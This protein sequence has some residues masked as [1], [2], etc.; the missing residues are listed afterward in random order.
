MEV[1]GGK[2][3]TGKKEG[4]SVPTS[5]EST[6]GAPMPQTGSSLAGASSWAAGRA[7]LWGRQATLA[8]LPGIIP[9][10]R[11]DPVSL[12]SRSLTQH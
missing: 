8:A 12:V 10:R 11:N 6:L 9:C 1:R 7:P 4:G 3:T 5:L 2:V